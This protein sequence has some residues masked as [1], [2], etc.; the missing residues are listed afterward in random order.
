MSN[1]F[2]VGLNLMNKQFEYDDSDPRTYE[3]QL[4]D[5]QTV[6]DTIQCDITSYPGRGNEQFSQPQFGKV[7]TKRDRRHE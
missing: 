2:Q 5:W 4:R 3:E 6:A 7:V 1:T